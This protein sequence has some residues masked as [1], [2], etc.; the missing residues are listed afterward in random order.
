MATAHKAFFDSNN[1]LEAEPL[2]W[3]FRFIFF[4]NANAVL[5]PSPVSHLGLFIG[6]C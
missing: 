4:H 3:K 2:T 1:H 5:L 6:D